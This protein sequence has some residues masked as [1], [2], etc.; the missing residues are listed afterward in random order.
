MPP[1]LPPTL[2]TPLPFLPPKIP[3]PIRNKQ[4]LS[5]LQLPPRRKHYKQHPTYHLRRRMHIRH[6]VRI[7]K[8]RPVPMHRRIYRN[9]IPPVRSIL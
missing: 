4:L 9:I 2:T 5:S 3:L 7:H 8:P 6:T 1:L